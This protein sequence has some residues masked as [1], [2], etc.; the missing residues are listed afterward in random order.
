[1]IDPKVNDWISDSILFALDPKVEEK[2][3]DELK[4]F[5]E[6]LAGGT[7][8][9]NSESEFLRSSHFLAEGGTDKHSVVSEFIDVLQ[10]M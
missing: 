7:F 3:S 6:A 1:M 9:L 10:G 4:K 2:I 5:D 8:H